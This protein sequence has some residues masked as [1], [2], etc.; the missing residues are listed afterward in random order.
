MKKF[1]LV[2]VLV[3]L[4]IF[5][6]SAYA[7]CAKFEPPDGTA[8]LIMGQDLG[9][10]GGSA[11]PNNNGYIENVGGPVPGGVTTYLSIP[12]LA[13]M[14]SITNY[15][16]GDICAQCITDN[17]LYK[18]S[19]LAVGL[20][21]VGELAN[22]NN[23]TRDGVLLQL[24]N[25]IKGRS[26]PVFLRIGY[27]YDGSWNNYNAAAYKLAYKRIVDK[28]RL[29]GVSNCAYV[30]QG[31]GYSNDTTYL[32]QWYPGDDYVD[33][34]AY[35]HFK[36]ASNGSGEI[37]LARSHQKP[38][39]IAEATPRGDIITT[40]YSWDGWFGPLFQHIQNNKDVIKALAY[41]N[42]NWNAQPMWIGQGWGDTRVQ[43]NA[44]IKT[45]W[46]AEISS[47][48]WLNAS[49]TLF[50]TL[51]CDANQIEDTSVNSINIFPNPSNGE[52]NIALPFLEEIKEISISDIN[53]KEIYNSSDYSNINLKINLNEN[54][55]AGVY[56]VNIALRSGAFSKQKIIVF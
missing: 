7:Q 13:G 36:Y 37:A 22:I 12:S 16:G 35:S 17:T 51:D 31:S 3:L 29:A 38:L 25:W 28:M 54:I 6:R 50:Q 53:G 23:G 8:I 44:T 43:N 4:S 18:N 47:S 9:S 15:G 32:K 2:G 27:E 5:T 26:Q 10:L 11:S 21:L 24:A 40:G 48:F 30:W 19:V 39:M 46:L 1:K 20:Y 55:S 14:T 33:W 34:M 42:A 41:I 56:V 49:P 45:K 52:I